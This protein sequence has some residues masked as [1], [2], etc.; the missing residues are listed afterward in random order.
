MYLRFGAVF[1]KVPLQLCLQDTYST[2]V[3]G[4]H[5]VR[6][7]AEM[8]LLVGVSPLPITAF[9]RAPDLETVDLQ[10]DRVVGERV[11]E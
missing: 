11:T 7:L 1:I 4:R 3:T 9:V 10:P 6:A 2:E 8:G 5:G